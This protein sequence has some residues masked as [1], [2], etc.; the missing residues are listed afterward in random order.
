ML[1]KM[2]TWQAAQEGPYSFLVLRLHGYLGLAGLICYA[3][4]ACEYIPNFFV[5]AGPGCR[6]VVE[7]TFIPY[8]RSRL[9]WNKACNTR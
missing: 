6:S 2:A 3:E 1:V 5:V 8:V 4:L 7:L 9:G